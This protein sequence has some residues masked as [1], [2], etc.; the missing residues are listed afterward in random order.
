MLN[1]THCHT[2]DINS[3]LASVPV[4][5]RNNSHLLVP[6]HSP[7]VKGKSCLWTADSH[8]YFLASFLHHGGD[9]EERSAPVTSV[10]GSAVV[11]SPQEQIAQRQNSSQGTIIWGALLPCHIPFSYKNPESLPQSFVI[12]PLVIQ[13]SFLGCIRKKQ[14]FKPE[15]QHCKLKGKRGIGRE[16]RDNEMKQI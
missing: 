15:R 12:K 6:W 2:W 11:Y 9:M 1:K 7:T 5:I 10:R 14:R 4:G 8:G 16:G 3:Q 13:N